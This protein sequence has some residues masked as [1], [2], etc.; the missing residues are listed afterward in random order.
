M[1]S[2][3]Q[4]ST[5]SAPYMAQF[6]QDFNFLPYPGSTRAIHGITLEIDNLTG[7]LTLFEVIKCH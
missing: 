1:V 2:E 5:V 3:R 6:F 7:T 4:I